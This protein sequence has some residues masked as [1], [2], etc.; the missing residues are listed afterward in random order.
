[1]VGRRE[2][3]A[4]RDRPHLLERVSENSYVE[5]SRRYGNLYLKT[6]ADITGAR[7]PDVAEF[8]SDGPPA[9]TSLSYGAPLIAG[10]IVLLLLG[11]ALVRR[12]M[13]H[14]PPRESSG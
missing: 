12:R 7:A 2:L 8:D 3:V 5:P 1:M 6:V 11:V 10:G 4:G 14:P 13:S 9:G